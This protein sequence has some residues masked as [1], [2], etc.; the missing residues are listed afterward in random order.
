MKPL[1]D[2]MREVVAERDNSDLAEEFGMTKEEAAELSFRL[3]KVGFLGFRWGVYTSFGI[4]LAALGG[5]ALYR[6]FIR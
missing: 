5:V 6:F 2:L 1:K 3:L 4:M